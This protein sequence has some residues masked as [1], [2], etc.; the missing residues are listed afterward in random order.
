[1][2]ENSG[3]NAIR[4][5][6]ESRLLKVY[7]PEQFTLVM[8]FSFTFQAERVRDGKITKIGDP[9]L[10][11]FERPFDTRLFSSKQQEQDWLDLTDR[12]LSKILPFQL[13]GM[14]GDV[15]HRAMD[16]AANELGIIALDKKGFIKAHAKEYEQG[17]KA[18]LELKG[19]GRPPAYSKVK[20]EEMLKQTISS[21]K[22][23]NYGRA[24]TIAE[25][26]KEISKRQPMT[27]VN[28]KQL[29]HR[30]GLLYSTYK[31]VT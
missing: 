17:V 16:L 10:R 13:I 28:L 3:Q 20:L 27:T 18:D 11:D 6:I 9:V 23:R 7:D 19:R 25:A 4:F 8:R 31:K 14:T 21:Y 15:V 1:M 22:R 26:A 24:P 30:H 29:L 12:K 5:I 2:S